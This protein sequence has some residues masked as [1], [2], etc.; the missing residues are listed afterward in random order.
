MNVQVK[1]EAQAVIKIPNYFSSIFLY[2]R[3]VKSCKR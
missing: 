1:L 2:V 3:F